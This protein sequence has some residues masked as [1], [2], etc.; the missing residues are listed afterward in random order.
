MRMTV[1]IIFIL[2]LFQSACNTIVYRA[3]GKNITGCGIQNN[4]LKDI[5]K[6]RSKGRICG[7]TY[8]KAA[9]PVS[10]DNKLADASLQ[11]SLDMA[12]N[13]FLSHTGSKGNNLSERLSSVGYEWT[14]CAEN[15]GHGYRSSEETVRSW[16]KSRTHCKNIMNPDFKEIG[17]AYAKSKT[18]R[19]YWTMILGNPKQ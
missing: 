18:L 1:A 14:A 3:S 15:I 16:L 7:N 9:R 2:L 4:I 8:Y 10:W 19:T 17:A 11:H 6:A 13:G 5:N 12:E